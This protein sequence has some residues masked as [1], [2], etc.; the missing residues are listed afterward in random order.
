MLRRLQTDD[1]FLI[2]LSERLLNVPT[3]SEKATIPKLINAARGVSSELKTWCVEEVDRQTSGGMSP[4]MGFD[5]IY[6]APRLVAYTLLDVL[7]HPAWTAAASATEF[8]LEANI[9]D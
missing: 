6:G 9:L 3:P 1:S 4:E 7:S 8:G 2:M 5:M